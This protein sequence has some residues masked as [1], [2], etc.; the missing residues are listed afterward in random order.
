MQ[1]YLIW[2]SITIPHAHFICLAY[3]IWGKVIV[4]ADLNLYKLAPASSCLGLCSEESMPG[5]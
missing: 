4:S 5:P 2:H 3:Q 1:F